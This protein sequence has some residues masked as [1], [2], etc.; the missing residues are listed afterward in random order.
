MG[1]C[2]RRAPVLAAEAENC[3]VVSPVRENCFEDIIMLIIVLIVIE[4]L[5]AVLSD[6]EAP[7]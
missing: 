1:C 2:R 3:A 4:F 7:C 5:C 6:E